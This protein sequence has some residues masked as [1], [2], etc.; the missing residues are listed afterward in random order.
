MKYKRRKRRSVP[1]MG[2]VGGLND[3][4]ENIAV[5][6]GLKAQKSKPYSGGL[7]QAIENFFTGLGSVNW[8]GALS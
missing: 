6:K 4:A 2:T 5:S 8:G 7:G 3:L 1:R